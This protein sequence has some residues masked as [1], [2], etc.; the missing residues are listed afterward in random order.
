MQWTH[1]YRQCSRQLLPSCFIL[2]YLSATC[3][4]YNHIAGTCYCCY[5]L[6]ARGYIH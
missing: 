4:Y 5:K 3:Y 6:A 1:M 2:Y